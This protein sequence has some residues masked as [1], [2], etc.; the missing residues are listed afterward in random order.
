MP[1]RSTFTMARLKL[2]QFGVQIISPRHGNRRPV[3]VEDDRAILPHL[4]A[5]YLQAGLLR[6][7]KGLGDV[8]L[9]EGLRA[10]GHFRRPPSY[11]PP[12]R[13]S[14]SRQPRAARPARTCRQ[15]SRPASHEARAGLSRHGQTTLSP[16]MPY[17][18]AAFAV[19]GVVPVAA[20]PAGGHLGWNFAPP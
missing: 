11:R 9:L 20:G 18:H 8:A 1:L 2:S 12:P 3:E 13:P 15:I 14:E 6:A 4:R 16:P 7:L 10:A 19:R 5:L 17:R